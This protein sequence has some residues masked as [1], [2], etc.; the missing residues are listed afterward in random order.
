MKDSER[1]VELLSNMDSTLSAIKVSVFDVDEINV[2]SKPLRRL[3]LAVHANT[4]EV[5]AIPGD[6]I[7]LTYGCMLGSSDTYD[8]WSRLGQTQR[9]CCVG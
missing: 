8:S 4:P 7:R 2:L 5:R 1:V 6:S 9:A 3:H